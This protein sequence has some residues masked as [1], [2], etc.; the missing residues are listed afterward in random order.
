M[1]KGVALI[2]VLDSVVVAVVGAV[3]A[4]AILLRATVA[5]Y[6]K[7]A[8]GAGSSRSV[9]QPRI[10]KAMGITFVI[11][12]MV[13]VLVGLLGAGLRLIAQEIRAADWEESNVEALSL[14]LLNLVF[15]SLILG[16]MLPT[17]RG[18]ATL[19]SLCYMVVIGLCGCV[20]Q[21]ISLLVG[22]EMMKELSVL[23]LVA[24]SDGFAAYKLAQK[25]SWRERSGGSIVVSLLAG[26]LVSTV[27]AA[28][29]IPVAMPGPLR[30]GLSDDILV[31]FLVLAVLLSI[32]SVIGSVLGIRHAGSYQPT[33]DEF[34]EKLTREAA[35]DGGRIRFSCMFCQR[36]LEYPLRYAG[37]RTQCPGCLLMTPIPDEVG[38]Q[39]T[40]TGNG[41]DRDSHSGSS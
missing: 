6:N 23:G 19:V 21:A 14:I 37:Q 1:P 8:G 32:G 16:A 36:G 28:L 31:G 10:G 11:M 9:P 29:L 13:T 5:L 39:P 34:N 4:M 38:E 18:R 40:E 25:F 15:I 20:L 22:K 33:S 3:I 30:A 41:D 12:V 24:T 27:S 35:E 2:G 26:F 17:A 7:V